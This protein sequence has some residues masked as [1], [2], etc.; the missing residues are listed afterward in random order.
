MATRK[1]NTAMV[2]NPAGRTLTI[3]G[4]KRRTARRST[5][6]RNPVAKAI[7]SNPRARRPVSRRHNPS[8]TSSL[9]V[10]AAMAAIGVSIFDAATVRLVP[11]QSALVRAGIKLG[12]AFAVQQWGAKLPLLGKHKNDI[13]LVL[14]V[15]GFID[16]MNLYIWP[17]ITSAVSSATSNLIAVPAAEPSSDQT[18]A[19]VY[20]SPWGQ[21]QPFVA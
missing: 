18:T 8:S 20:G 4:S 2:F 17:L 3:N 13:A 6:R 16:V 21:R 12:G 19:G 5:K 10:A 9:F 11:A 1:P 14:G 15:A 7:A